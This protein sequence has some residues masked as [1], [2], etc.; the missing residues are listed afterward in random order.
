MEDLQGSNTPTTGMTRWRRVALFLLLIVG[1]GFLL[2]GGMAA[3]S[4]E[5]LLGPGSLPIVHAEYEGFTRRPWSELATTS[6]PT[7]AFMTVVFRVYGA[8]NVAFAVLAIAITL[9][10]FRRGEPW[11][12]WA[13]LVGYTIALGSAI[14]YDRV[15]NAIG[16]FEMSEYVGLLTVYAALA[17]TAPFFAANRH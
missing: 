7:A 14:T 5:H 6:P 11:A 8:Y 9:T 4:P 2:W 13:L 10:A 17:I 16:P 3:L 15:V 1:V 12:W